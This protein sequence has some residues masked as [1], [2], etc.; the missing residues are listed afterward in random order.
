[1][2][3]A[4][5]FD[6]FGVLALRGVNSFR[7]EILADD[8]Q[9]YDQAAKLTDELNRGKLGYDDFIASL[10]KLAGVPRT[11]VLKYT[12]DYQPNT[13]LL[14]YISQTLKPKYKIGIISNAGEDWVL[15][16]L[17]NNNMKLFDDIIL[18]YKTNFIKPEPEIYKMSAKNLGVK[19]EESIFI[20][21]I[22]RYCEGAEQVGM[23]TIWYQSFD[24]F[25]A[26]ITKLLAAV[27][28]N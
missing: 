13:E 4:V 14:N 25:I 6:F 7:K 9:K 1:M 16:I 21:D 3:K 20:D 2:I 15:K 28:D 19:E 27:S 24:G 26:E 11:A 10:A 22:L 5:I 12:E 23:S 18:S 17:G 8:P